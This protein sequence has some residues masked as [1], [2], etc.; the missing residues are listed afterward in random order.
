MI[1]YDGYR[2]FMEGY[3]YAVIEYDGYIEFMEGL[4]ICCD[5]VR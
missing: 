1:E 3:G 4:W 2:E 5:R